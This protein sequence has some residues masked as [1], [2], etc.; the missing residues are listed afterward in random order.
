MTLTDRRSASALVILTAHNSSR[1]MKQRAILDFERTTF[2]IY[3]PGPDYGRTARDL[4][5][6]GIDGSTPCAVVSNACRDNQ[7]VRFMSSAD[8]RSA[9]EIVAPAV[10]IVGNVAASSKVPSFARDPYRLEEAAAK[11]EA[12]LVANLPIS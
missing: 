8:L 1:E 4:M 10:L 6:C 5:N 9:R 11:L 7:K 3:M 2:A 12:N